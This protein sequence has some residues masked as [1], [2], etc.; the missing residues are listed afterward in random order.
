MSKKYRI[1][2]APSAAKDLKEIIRFIARDNATAAQTLAKSIRDK[3]NTVLT[4]NPFLCTILL[5]YPALATA[6]YRRLA[7]HK[8][9]SV[10]YVIVNS[11][12]KIMHIWDN[13]RNWD[14]I[15]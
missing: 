14:L 11:S 10:L 3:I 13:R 4:A 15:E 1:E 8:H 6:G 12:V 2:I 9:Y 5:D 7:V